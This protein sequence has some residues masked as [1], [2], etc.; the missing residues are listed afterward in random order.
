MKKILLFYLSS[1]IFLFSPLTVY[2]QNVAGDSATISSADF[3]NL[4][5]KLVLKKIGLYRV[6]KQHDSP[7]VNSV[8]KFLIVC[9]KYQIDCYLLPS[10]A[11]V[12]STFGKYI[13][14]QSFNPFGWG[15][16]LIIFSSWDEAI[17][18]VAKNLKLKYINK[19]ANTIEEIGLIYCENPD[20][21]KKVRYFYNL[22][23][24]EEEN[25][26]LLK[27]SWVE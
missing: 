15:R 12:E 18:T 20:W 8:D 6:L 26:L 2:S 14:P 22:F 7:L 3:I 11:G 13:Y 1:F 19:G 17:E 16:G 21:S 5:S 10:I 23:K 4:N 9:Q 25:L 24:K 27:K